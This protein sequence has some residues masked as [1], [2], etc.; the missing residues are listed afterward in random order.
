MLSGTVTHLPV[1]VNASAPPNFPA[2]VRVAPVIVPMLPLP[3]LSATVEPLASSKPQAPT[4]PLA[5]GVT[6]NVTAT[7]F[8]DPVAPA[9]VIVTVPV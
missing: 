1:P 5:G 2:V 9:A 3:D 4:S 7:V 8:G 6:V